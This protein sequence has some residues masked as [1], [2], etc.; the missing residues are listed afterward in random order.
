[1]SRLRPGRRLFVRVDVRVDVV[2][3]E[4]EVEEDEERYLTIYMCL[5]N[6]TDTS[7][8][9]DYQTKTFH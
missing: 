7:D 2:G 8:E 1:M 6:H 5:S 9:L 3:V 4:E